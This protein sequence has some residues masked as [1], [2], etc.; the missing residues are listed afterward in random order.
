[1]RQSV[2]YSLFTKWWR[3]TKTWHK[4]GVYFVLL[5]NQVTV[6]V[7]DKKIYPFTGT[8][9]MGDCT[10]YPLHISLKI[11]AGSRMCPSLE[12]TP[13]WMRDL[14]KAA[15][16]HTSGGTQNNPHISVTLKKTAQKHTHTHTVLICKH[17]A[18]PHNCCSF[19]MISPSQL[20][21][22]QD[23]EGNILVGACV[24]AVYHPQRSY[25]L[26]SDSIAL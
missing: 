23:H 8:L 18:W 2:C 14:P 11:P 21:S 19:E 1:M 3:A 6:K 17:P 22:K 16:L 10:P 13:D 26:S 4:G 5:T 20:E 9:C 15:R 12:T 7:N 24:R 25:Y